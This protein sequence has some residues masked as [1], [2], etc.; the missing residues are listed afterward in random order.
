M[1]T[2][3]K[4]RFDREMVAFVKTLDIKAAVFGYDK[5]DVYSKFKDLLVKAR[6]VC[7]ELVTEEYRKLELMKT[8]LL[9]VAEDP[10]ALRRLLDEWAEG[11]GALIGAP[12]E[13][14]PSPGEEESLPEPAEEKPPEELDQVLSQQLEDPAL[15]EGADD[16]L[17]LSM[18]LLL[19]ENQALRARLQ[20]L[21]HRQELLQRAHDIV[22]EARL[23]REEIIRKAQTTAEEELFL[24]RARR[25]EEEA[26][27]KEE[28]DRL[29]ARKADLE[30][31]HSR[32]LAYVMEGQSL[33]DQLRSYTAGLE[34]LEE[35]TMPPEKN[36]HPDQTDN[37]DPPV[38]SI[39]KGTGCT[40]EAMPLCELA[41]ER[42][43]EIFPHPEQVEEQP[44]L[45]NEPLVGD[46][47]DPACLDQE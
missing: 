5:N 21:D 12:L 39:D 45:D 27:F 28:L 44:D 15:E 8:Q 46:E 25:R 1:E 33:F 11:E 23:E 31:R 9:E 35:D 40:E 18:N 2:I 26:A 13:E 20:D 32:Y 16:P 36:P 17:E 24:Y 7:E 47:A 10:E 37:L 43:E 34:N 22:S 3:V 4:Y 42:P 14:L 6:D 41:E 29:E 19:E 38:L 30:G